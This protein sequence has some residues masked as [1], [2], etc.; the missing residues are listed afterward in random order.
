MTAGRERQNDVPTSEGH[1]TRKTFERLHIGVWKESTS[2]HETQIPGRGGRT[3]ENVSLQVLVSGKR[4]A[5]VGTEDHFGAWW[6]G[7]GRFG[8]F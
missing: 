7:G 1:M 4:L 2:V 5:A 3:S 6:T 8:S